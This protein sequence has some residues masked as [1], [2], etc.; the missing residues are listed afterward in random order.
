MVFDVAIVGG[1]LVG[2]SLAL[3]LGRAGFHCALVEAGAPVG[4]RPDAWDSRIYAVSP[5]SQSFLESIGVWQE[6]D[7]ARLAPVY[8]MQVQGDRGGQL[9]F[10][11]HA[12][13]ADRRHD[14]VGAEPGA[15]R[16]THGSDSLQR[17]AR[18]EPR[19]VV[20][21]TRLPLEIEAAAPLH[22]VA[23]EERIEPTPE[24][25]RHSGQRRIPEPVDRFAGIVP[26][27][28]QL[29][30]VATSLEGISKD[31][32]VVGRRS[33]EHTSELQSH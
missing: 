1:G 28:V 11:A 27:V 15:R 4:P 2:T 21:E 10:S 14:L 24:I 7:V 8:D 26:Q 31:Q 3:G 32:L 19:A 30:G 18:P 12:S 23:R 33:E 25:L 16:K 5:A 22:C 6:I 29:I 13:G 17:D 20:V 9:R